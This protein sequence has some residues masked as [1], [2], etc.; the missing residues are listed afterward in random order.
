[1]EFLANVTIVHVTLTSQMDEF[2]AGGLANVL[3]AFAKMNDTSDECAH[4][5][6]KQLCKDAWLSEMC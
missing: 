3:Y 1:V 2:D 4:T 5:Y 6:I